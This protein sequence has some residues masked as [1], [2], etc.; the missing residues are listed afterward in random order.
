MLDPGRKN[1]LHRGNELRRK[2]SLS[3]AEQRIFLIQDALVG[4]GYQMAAP[5]TIVY[6]FVD[7]LSVLLQAGRIITIWDKTTNEMVFSSLGDE[8]QIARHG[9]P[10]PHD[11]RIPLWNSRF[12]IQVDRLKRDDPDMIKGG[13]PGKG[14][15]IDTFTAQRLED[16]QLIGEV[17]A[18]LQNPGSA[19]VSRQSD[20]AF[21][22]KLIEA[23]SAYRRPSHTPPTSIK[24]RLKE[25]SELLRPMGRLLDEVFFDLRNSHVFQSVQGDLEIVKLFAVAR[26][27]PSALR[28]YNGFFNYTASLLLSENQSYAIRRLLAKERGEEAAEQLIKDLESPLGLEDRSVA[29]TVF[30]SGNVG[31]GGR[32]GSKLDVAGDDAARRRQEIEDLVYRRIHQIDKEGNLHVFYVPVHVGGVPWL[33]FFT[34]TDETPTRDHE[35]WKRNYR[36]YRDVIPK[37]SSQI[38]TGAKEIYLGLLADKL[39][40]RLHSWKVG[41]YP[42][43]DLA[44][45][46][47]EDWQKINQVYP[48]DQVR[49]RVPEAGEEQHDDMMLHLGDGRKV[50][51]EVLEGSTFLRRDVNYDLLDKER[52]RR[53]CHDALRSYIR[54]SDSLQQQAAVY[55]THNL[56]NSLLRLRIVL[57]DA[58]L[59]S[60]SAKAAID[61]QI[62]ELITLEQFSNYLIT[63]KKDRKPAIVQTQDAEFKE[64][65]TAIQKALEVFDIVSYADNSAET[66]RRIK[67]AGTLALDL[68]A[69][70]AV[71]N[72]SPLSFCVEQMNVVING[73]ISNALKYNTW[74]SPALRISASANQDGIYLHVRNPSSRSPAEVR[75]LA[76]GLSDPADMFLDF[77]GVNLIHLACHACRYSPPVWKEEAGEL[78]A[79]VQVARKLAP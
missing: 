55:N 74:Q 39:T 52:V 69:L 71:K 77:V 25:I 12:V 61:S 48:Y 15:K 44:R 21:P 62:G 28:R 78:V 1:P 4:L 42:L 31:F 45:R 34:F 72:A 20:I 60:D 29:D 56:R 33:A 23:I 63:N 7:Y 17:L 11:D 50:L 24:L 67:E 18:H 35:S 41:A 30:S 22:H 57:R 36:I 47:S 51:V 54:L 65:W 5:E 53:A 64:L 14:I 46:V 76:E 16:Y 70:T 79:T 59:D 38:R 3:H 37:I 32:V 27:V 9:Q 8:D 13:R 43:E 6:P 26:T 49:L 75:E 2:E 58:N 73:L 68:S 19:A 66:L 40:T 10:P